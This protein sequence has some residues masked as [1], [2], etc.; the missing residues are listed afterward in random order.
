MRFPQMTEPQKPRMKVFATHGFQDD[1]K[2]V[3]GDA[4]EVALEAVAKRERSFRQMLDEMQREDGTTYPALQ[5]LPLLDPSGHEVRTCIFAVMLNDNAWEL[6][7][8]A[9]LTEDFGP[10]Q[11]SILERWDKEQQPSGDDSGLLAWYV[12]RDTKT[13]NGMSE[14]M[15][16]DPNWAKH[17]LDNTHW[18]IEHTV[19]R[20]TPRGRV[21]F[22]V[23]V[24][25]L[26]FTGPDVPHR[27]VVVGQDGQQRVRLWAET[28]ERAEDALRYWVY[29]LGNSD[30]D[31]AQAGETVA[32][33][34]QLKVYTGLAQNVPVRHQNMFGIFYQ[35][36]PGGGDASFGG[37][38]GNPLP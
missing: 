6:L 21:K 1:E 28:Q 17:I 33:D 25:G 2:R 36:A 26:D 22:T 18:G 23:S 35:E 20:N 24:M 37:P 9:D 13:T 7:A 29:L 4:V 31:L 15:I 38:S 34:R 14:Y 10:A 30:L 12:P 5:V 32:R 8:V 16:H 3:T 19:Q 27:W 11:R